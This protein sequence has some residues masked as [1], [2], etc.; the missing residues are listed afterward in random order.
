MLCIVYCLLALGQW[1]IVFSQLCCVKV[2]SVF[3]WGI[4]TTSA[5]DMVLSLILFLIAVTTKTFY[6]AHGLPC[7]QVVSLM[8]L[9]L[10]LVHIGDT[11]S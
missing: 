7:S 2:K 6:L 1:L 5:S 11:R 10:V 8:I 9:S 4:L 3:I